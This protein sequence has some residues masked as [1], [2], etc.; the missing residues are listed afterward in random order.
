MDEKPDDELA[1]ELREAQRIGQAA[2]HCVRRHAEIEW[3]RW[4]GGAPVVDPV[5]FHATLAASNDRHR[6][7]PLHRADLAGADL[8]AALAMV[9][10]QVVA[11]AGEAIHTGR[12]IAPRTGIVFP[13]PGASKPAPAKLAKDFKGPP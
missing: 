11:K 12:A 8:D 6:D 5:P 1:E 7:A 13:P 4:R 10:W 2:C 3:L 9:A